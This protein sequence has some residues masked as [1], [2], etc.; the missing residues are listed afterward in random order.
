MAR[1]ASRGTWRVD[2]VPLHDFSG[3]TRSVPG[4]PRAGTIVLRLRHQA[5]RSPRNLRLRQ[6]KPSDLLDPDA[7]LRRPGARLMVLAPH[8]DD[9]SLA[10]GGLIQRALECGAA[11]SVVF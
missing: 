4:Q 11:V 2:P 8:P 1:K 3:S 6:E 9:E 10:A 5:R 7:L